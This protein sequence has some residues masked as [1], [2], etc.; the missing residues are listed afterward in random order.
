[1]KPLFKL[2]ILSGNTLAVTAQLYRGASANASDSDGNSALMYAAGRGHLSLCRLLLDFGADVTM[3]NAKGQSA[4]SIAQ[5]SGHTDAA[6]L[7]ISYLRP[8]APHPLESEDI[9]E[10]LAAGEW[11]E[12]VPSSSPPPAQNW[13]LLAQAKDRETAFSHFTPLDDSEDWT[14]IDLEFPDEQLRE[15]KKS[16]IGNEYA[17]MVK[18]AIS[19][20]LQYGSVNIFDL[21]NMFEDHSSKE[22]AVNKLCETLLANGI[23]VEEN[24]PDCFTRLF[25][26]MEL[27]NDGF[28]DD[29]VVKNIFHDFMHSFYD[30]GEV[31]FSYYADIA[32]FMQ[33]TDDAFDELVEQRDK[34]A[35][36]LLLLILQC[37]KAIPLSDACQQCLVSISPEENASEDEEDLEAEADALFSDFQNFHT[38]LR[39]VQAELI[40]PYDTPALFEILATLQCDIDFI[41]LFCQQLLVTVGSIH[42]AASSDVTAWVE[43]FKFSLET[44]VASRARMVEGNLRLALYFARRYKHLGCEFSDVVQEANIGLMRATGKYDPSREARFATY[45]TW[46]IRQSIIRYICNNFNTLR[47]PVHVQDGAYDSLGI[48][49]HGWEELIREDSVHQEVPLWLNRHV[50]MTTRERELPLIRVRYDYLPEEEKNTILAAREI[51]DFSPEERAVCTEKEAL[52]A[53]L[54]EDLKEKEKD[55]LMLRFG[56]DVSHDHTLEEVGQIYGVTRERVRQIEA[57]ALQRLKHPTRLRMMEEFQDDY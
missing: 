56:I 33:P 37:P 19:H 36:T 47:I 16:W 20:A 49:A 39:E 42:E 57:K 3:T 23:L 13:G 55:V 21:Y 52:V 40:R 50:M 10:L 12:E 32:R 2:A 24:C 44:I 38:R 14:D 15:R 11:E 34:A 8:H 4:F 5:N 43:K 6:K 1:M 51:E 48:D 26:D 9:E 17:D 30:D 7:L 31:V 35:W 41:Q 53:S 46:R 22:H 28:I 27:Y 45:A 18:L 25:H 54:L 29:D